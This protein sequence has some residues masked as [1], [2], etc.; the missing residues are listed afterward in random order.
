ME[1]GG[2]LQIRFNKLALASPAKEQLQGYY[3]Q[4]AREGLTAL[5]EGRLST[6]SVKDDELVKVATRLIGKEARLRAKPMIPRLTNRYGGA[7][8]EG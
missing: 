3:S 5:I 6:A 1:F 8:R 7:V 4:G 2:P